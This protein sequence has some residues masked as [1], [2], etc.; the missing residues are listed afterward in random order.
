MIN[1][2]SIKKK[3][4]IYIYLPLLQYNYN[5]KLKKIIIIFFLPEY[6]FL[7]KKC[8]FWLWQHVFK[9]NYNLFCFKLI[10][11]NIFILFWYAD[12]KNKF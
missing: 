1:M 7:S 9:K 4:Y 10:F 11:F 3:N 12:V 8:L 2:H 6:L 5:K